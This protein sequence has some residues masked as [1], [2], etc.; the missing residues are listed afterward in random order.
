[1]SP[2]RC[3]WVLRRA[4]APAVARPRP[5]V[6]AAAVRRARPRARWAL[7]CAGG[8]GAA[9]AGVAGSVALIN[10]AGNLP[11]PVAPSPADTIPAWAAER[12]AIAGGDPVSV[13]EPSTMLVLLGALVVL[14]LL[15]G[16][17]VL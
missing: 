5:V 2:I 13:P 3:W 9:G 12:A 7:V 10:A 14:A 11:P 6:A 1:M 8:V 16:W 4:V 15:R 17:R